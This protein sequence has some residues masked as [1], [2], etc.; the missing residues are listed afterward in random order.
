MPA[1]ESYEKLL[2]IQA[3]V[4]AGLVAYFTAN[5][6]TAYGTRSTA[7]IP[8]SAVLVMYQEGATEGHAATSQTTNTGQ[9]ENDWF[10][11]EIMVEVDTERVLADAPPVSGFATLHDYRVARVKTLFLR[12]AMAGSIAGITGLDLG[13]YDIVVIGSG[14]E[15]RSTN[16]DGIDVSEISFPVQIRIKSDAWPAAVAP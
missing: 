14:G 11:G 10:S 8:D 12:G 7:T 2:D 4:E 3:N 13:F 5:G 15:Q 6:L 9:K 16:P 1:A